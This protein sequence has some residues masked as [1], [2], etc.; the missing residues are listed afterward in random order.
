MKG[1][2]VKAMRDDELTVEIK[3]LREKLHALRVQSVSEKIEDNSQFGRIKRDIAR[4]RTEVRR[5]ELQSASA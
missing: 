5:R 2:E 4:M 1:S 3:R